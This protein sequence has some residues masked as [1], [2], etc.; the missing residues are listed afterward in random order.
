MGGLCGVK[1]GSRTTTKD[2]DYIVGRGSSS[3]STQKIVN[4]LAAAVSRVARDNNL[5]PEWMNTRAAGFA[6]RYYSDIINNSNQV[7]WRSGKLT[8]YYARFD[9]QLARKLGRI[10]NFVMILKEFASPT[11][12]AA[13]T[14]NVQDA[15]YF[16]YQVNGNGG[17]MNKATL[18]RIARFADQS[19]DVLIAD[20]VAVVN[21]Q[22]RAIT[23]SDGFASDV[24]GWG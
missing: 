13:L 22:Y 24:L 7:L 8:V 16:L 1:L 5:D 19:A 21:T 15:A 23:G 17:P 20:S 18:E 2:V 12:Q 6:S 9:F 11:V 14:T 4:D 10:A 3:S